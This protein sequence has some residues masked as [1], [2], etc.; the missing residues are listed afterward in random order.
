MSVSAD[1]ADMGT[2]RAHLAMLGFVFLVS[3][4]FPVG[5]AITG[6][7]AP[8]VLT[9]LRFCLAAAIF[10]GIATWKGLWQRPKLS[11]FPVYILIAV[12]LNIFFVTMF[13]ALRYT[14]ALNAGAVFTL[15]PAFTAIAGYLLLRQTVSRRQAACLAL[16]AAGAI[17]VLFGSD[18]GRL[19]RFEIGTGETIFLFGVMSY[20][21]YSPLMRLLNRGEPLEVFNFWILACGAV[22]LLVYGH[23]DLLQTNWP[24]VPARAFIGV[25]Y[26][27]V[28]PTASSFF[29][30]T[31]ASLRLPSGPVMAYT[32]LLPS[33][34]L[35]ETLALGAPWPG[36]LT[37]AGVAVTA[38]ATLILQRDT[39]KRG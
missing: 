28:F 12:V 6:D 17:L 4:S 22:I 8:A 9:A 7:L 5:H 33:F 3:T 35:F 18:I 36:M 1:R 16:G 20:A 38:V 27:A 11:R 30:A 15:L 21:F 13:E 37:L 19:L 26:L 39:H 2:G 31:Y 25:A 10:A 34:V 32:Y 23:D 14:S 24:E 29:F